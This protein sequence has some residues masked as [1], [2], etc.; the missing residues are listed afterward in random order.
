MCQQRR[1]REAEDPVLRA[2]R[3]A[4]KR[5]EKACE[6]AKRKSKATGVALAERLEG[7]KTKDRDLLVLHED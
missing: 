4:K 7:S 1:E 2:K 6:E 3:A 5:E